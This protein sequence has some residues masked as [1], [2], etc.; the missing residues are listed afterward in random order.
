MTTAISRLRF[1]SSDQT[2]IIILTLIP[3]LLRDHSD[4]VNVS[5][6]R[7]SLSCNTFMRYP[8]RGVIQFVYFGIFLERYIIYTLCGDYD[9]M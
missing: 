7:T 2:L 9:Y 4:S 1:T 8:H 6:S 5:I 3:T